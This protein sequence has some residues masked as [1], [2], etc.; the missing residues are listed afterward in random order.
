MSKPKAFTEDAKTVFQCTQ[1]VIVDK[2][3]FKYLKK[4]KMTGPCYEYLLTEMNGITD[5]VTNIQRKKQF[6]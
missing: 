5:N 3:T 4:K 2:V 1:V 6:Y